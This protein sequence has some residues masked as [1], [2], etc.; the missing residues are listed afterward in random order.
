[1]NTKRSRTGILAV[2]VAL[3]LGATAC[4]DF[5]G[6]TSPGR[7]LD[8]DLNSPLAMPALVTGMSSDFSAALDE[9]A[10]L[11]G[12]ASDE[13]T[14]SGSYFATGLFRRGKIDMEEVDGWWELAQRARWVSEHGIDRLRA[15]LDTAGAYSGNSLTV[16]A[17]LYA[18][19]ANR[20]FGECFCETVI[21]SGPAQPIS[22]SF[23]RA[24]RWADSAI[25]HASLLPDGTAKDLLLRVAHG[26]RAQAYVGL[27]DWGAA[28]ADAALVPTDF[29]FQALYDDNSAREENVIYNE[30]WS[31]PE[32]SAY[33]VLAGSFSPPDPRAPW[34]NCNVTPRPLGC[35]SR[36]GASGDQTPHYRQDKYPERGG[37]VPVVKGT[38]MRLIEAEERLRAGDFVNAMGKINEV[39]AFWGLGDLAAADS[40]EAFTHL[41]NERHLTLWLEARRLFDLRRWNHPFLMG[42]GTVYEAENPRHSCIPIARIECVTN[43]NLSGHPSCAG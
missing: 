7:V 35:T 16:R 21:D 32:M 34:T 14:G 23:Q 25:A 24:V 39:R 5:F 20:V 37:D 30:T 31:R 28:V 36:Y 33:A 19:L 11:V 12:R 15:V 6:V 38:E 2:T 29:V 17:F 43:P 10:F 26:V 18:A 9:I 1:M 27:D 22:T 3:T 4:G 41:D 42:G 40:A 13:M 8:E